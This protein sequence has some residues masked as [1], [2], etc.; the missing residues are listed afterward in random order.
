MEVGLLFSMNGILALNKPSGMCS[1]GPMN[2]KIPELWEL[3]QTRYP[4]GHIAHRIDKFTSGIN[5]VGTSKDKI[6][7]LTK[8]WHQIT[9]KTYLAII[10]NPTWAEITINAPIDGKSAV[11]SFAI[12][13]SFGSFS[14]VRCE[15]IQNGRTHQIRRHLKSIGSPIVGDTKYKGPETEARAGQLL[16]AWRLELRLPNEFGTPGQ[17]ITVQAPIPE[18]FKQFNFNW[19]YW[20]AGKN[21]SLEN[22]TVP[23]NWI[24]ST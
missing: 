4:E 13:E 9:K 3:L 14:L 20:D 18:D 12:I 10:N 8:N 23:N 6:C 24:R 21:D 7:Y 22:W 1:Q 15:L 17:W 19:D 11:T 16:H 2:S 5:L